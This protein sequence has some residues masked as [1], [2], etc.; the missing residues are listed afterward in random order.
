MEQKIIEKITKLLALA[1]SP[2]EAEAKLAATRAQ[3]LL[4]KYNLTMTQVEKQQGRAASDEKF[5]HKEMFSQCRKSTEDLYV[6]SLLGQFFFVAVVNRYAYI[7]G[8]KVFG[9]SLLGRHH[10][11]KIAEYMYDFLKMQFKQLF[12]SYRERTGCPVTSK[13]DYYYGLYCGL[14][15]QLI[16]A[17]S[18]IE[19]ETGLV[20]SD[21]TELM[22]FMRSQFKNVRD[23]ESHQQQISD[24]NAVATGI[25]QGKNMVIARGVADKSKSPAQVSNQL[26]LAHIQ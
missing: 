21:E 23:S 25:E 22:A 11:V 18:R 12:A 3:E 6:L 7:N 20:V 8:K 24:R 15:H 5:I 1:T 26:R 17:R 10:N 9:Y 4:V 2:V 14:H 16:G 13:K 19:T